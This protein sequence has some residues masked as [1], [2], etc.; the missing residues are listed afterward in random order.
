V[1]D[2]LLDLRRGAR[3]LLS[4]PGF[5]M[6]TILSLALGIGVNATVF[7]AANTLLI[8][9]MKLPRPGELVRV[10]RGHHSPFSFNNFTQ[11]RE[12]S[13]TLASL[14]AETQR[15]ASYALDGEPE[16]ARVALVSGNTFGALEV[17]PAI[18]R[19]FVRETDFTQ[20]ATPEV[21]IAHAF[22]VSRFGRDSSLVGQTIRLNDRPFTIIGIAPDGFTSSQRGWSADFFVPLGDYA[23]LTGREPATI[24]G[25]L[26]LTGRLTGDAT[27]SSTQAE[28]ATLATRLA[29][30]RDP[31]SPEITIKVRPATGVTEEIRLQAAIISAFLLAVSALILVIAATNVG[32]MLLARNSTR[33]REIGVRLALGA[34]RRRVI[35]MLVAE[36]AVLAVSAGVGA[37]LMA[38]WSGTLL[39]G[40][41]PSGSEIFFDFSPDWRVMSYTA[42]ASTMALL[43]FGLL[44]ALQSTRADVAEGIKNEAGIG[45][46]SGGRLRRRFLMVQVGLCS[47][48]L[49]V[50]LLF[51]RSLGRAQSV[52]TG[53]RPDGVLVASVDLSA[54]GLPDAEGVAFFERLVA[55]AREMPGVTSASYSRMVELTGSNAATALYRVGD[56]DAAV[57]RRSESDYFNTVGS[58]Y[59]ANLGIPIVRGRDF[60]PTDGVGA[61]PVVIV[62]ETFAARAWPGL[63]PIGQRLSMQGVSGPWMEVVGVSKNVLYHTLGEGP[64]QFYTVP[65]MQQ[66]ASQLSLEV[67]LADG[68]ATREVG[69][70][71]GR[72]VR[73]MDP[74]LPAPRVEPLTKMQEVVLLPARIG[75]GLLGGI[76]LLAVLLAAV[77]IAGVASYAV[78]QRRREIGIRSALGAQPKALLRSVLGETSR[79]VAIGGV[80]GL[81]GA[82]GVARVLSSQL[83]GLSALD[84]VTFASV[85]LLLAV[86]ALAASL[87]PARRVLRIAPQEALRPE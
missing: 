68:A 38:V 83:Y 52:D 64:K 45:S 47:L 85:P 4:R 67:R 36:S 8:Q 30:E 56:D 13:G 50:A 73:T 14:I 23:A 6:T 60:L 9:P 22:W 24:Q 41:F 33:R 12:R 65:Y 66:Y 27:P 75:A 78:T 51:V 59:H 44:P 84:P 49:S 37:W 72:L 77:G 70:A 16:V 20:A 10:Y 40:V 71:I 5:A 2:F 69:A 57:Q 32:N 26:Y 63:D 53:F 28:L 21:V 3:G 81:L 86:M 58:G 82:I 35:R 54:R 25:S 39:A 55:A 18:G 29:R 62:N 42:V 80:V 43:I 11:L 76:G 74:A 48:L 34:S 46:R 17:V 79:A 1:S 61:P 19:L 31:R 7:S 87:G 15:A